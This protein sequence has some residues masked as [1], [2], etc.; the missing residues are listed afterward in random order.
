MIIFQI[1]LDGL[2]INPMAMVTGFFWETCGC[3]GKQNE[4]E[5]KGEGHVGINPNSNFDNGHSCGLR[6]FPQLLP[7]SPKRAQKQKLHLPTL[8]LSW[9]PQPPKSSICREK[10]VGSACNTCSFQKF[11][12]WVLISLSAMLCF[13]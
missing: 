6:N 4:A 12:C 3:V 1:S 2:E 7:S 8:L 13:K 9:H 5:L 11:V 10:S